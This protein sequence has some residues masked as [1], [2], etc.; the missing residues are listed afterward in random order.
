MKPSLKA[1]KKAKES[2]KKKKELELD[3]QDFNMCLSE[4]I[5]PKC[6]GLLDV[7]PIDD[8]VWYNY[9]CTEL[10]CKFAHYGKPGWCD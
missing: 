3:K 1:I 5:C 4:R 7:K 10:A 8:N 9:E 6:A 2:V